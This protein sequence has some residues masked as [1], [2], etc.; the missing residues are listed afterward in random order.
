MP[1]KLIFIFNVWIVIIKIR[2]PLVGT[3]KIPDS[4]K[5]PDS[6]L[7]VPFPTSSDLDL[8]LNY[9]HQKLVFVHTKLDFE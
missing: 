4:E 3:K 7:T 1:V 5:I 6:D 9:L 8:V 2:D